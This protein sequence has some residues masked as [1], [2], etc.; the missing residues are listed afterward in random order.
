M[1]NYNYQFSESESEFSKM[2]ISLFGELELNGSTTTKGGSHFSHL[3]IPGGLFLQNQNNSHHSNTNSNLDP[4][5]INVMEDINFDRFID[6]VSSKP[7]TP[8]NITLKKKSIIK[9]CTKPKN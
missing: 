9:K 7:K 5:K 2:G 8:K 1:D 6:L 3:Y 4:A